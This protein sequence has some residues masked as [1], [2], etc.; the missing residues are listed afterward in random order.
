MGFCQE[1][2]TVDGRDQDALDWRNLVWFAGRVA[3]LDVG[4]RSALHT[5]LLMEGVAPLRTVSERDFGTSLCDV[6]YL[7]GQLAVEDF[8]AGRVWR[9]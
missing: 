6:F 7:D 8:G 9:D 1:G 5:R 2:S 4:T 3:A